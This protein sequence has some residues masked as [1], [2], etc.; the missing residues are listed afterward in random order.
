MNIQHIIFL[1]FIHTILSLSKR[2]TIYQILIAS[3]SSGSFLWSQL[4]YTPDRT[5]SYHVI[6]QHH[7]LMRC[8]VLFY[9]C[10][11]LTHGGRDKM[12]VIFQTTFSNAFSWIEMFKFRLKCNAGGFHV[13]LW[14][15]SMLNLG[16]GPYGSHMGP[17]AIGCNLTEICFGVFLAVPTCSVTS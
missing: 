6:W 17:S 3:I 13:M 9:L 1:I 7:L 11:A 2:K 16:H 5:Y 8:L 4:P 12:A 15:P 10:F 14:S